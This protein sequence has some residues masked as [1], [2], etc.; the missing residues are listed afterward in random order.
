[1]TSD[2][3][4]T[5]AA[6]AT[7]NLIPPSVNDDKL[8]KCHPGENESD[9]IEV[10]FKQIKQSHT[11]HNMFRDLGGDLDKNFF[12]PMPAVKPEIFQKVVEWTANHIAVPDPE[13][14]EDPT[15]RERVWFT[16]NDYEN[17]FFDVPADV[18]A[19]LLTAA[20]YLDIKH[21]YMYGCQKLAERIKD[22][23]PEEIR[24]MFGLEDD[25][26]P[27]DKDEIKK[28]NVWCNY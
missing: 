24:A 18:M 28:Q 14:K 7:E 6:P 22:K 9:I 17:K 4:E 27:E 26:T 19:E 3:P 20:N 13:V 25:L 5:S 23:S 10:P 12:F 8:I 1:M 16:L 11:F 15:T 2:G 21:L